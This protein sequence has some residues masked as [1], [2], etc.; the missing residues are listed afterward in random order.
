MS[1]DGARFSEL[2]MDCATLCVAPVWAS[3]G[4]SAL[5]ASVDHNGTATFIDTGKRRILVTAYHVLAKVRE[6]QA[7]NPG[8]G[9][10][11]NLASGVTPFYPQFDVVAEDPAADIAVLSFPF[12]QDWRGHAKRYFPIRQWPIP[13]PSKGEAVTIVGFP[14][15]M[16]RTFGSYGSFSPY[17][18]GMVVSND[19]G[20]HVVLANES[21]LT[22]VEN[23]VSRPG[24]IEPGGMSGAAGFILRG[25]CVHLA[26]FVY[27]GNADMLF[28]TPGSRL[29]IDGILH[30]RLPTSV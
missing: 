19:P 6:V 4:E 14:G 18:I 20:R 10:A 17:G 8:A 1:P 29:H 9:L 27:E 12:L 11:V 7:Q 21:R 24:G 30:P 2:I 3:L 16:R 22:T 26:G 13:I 15:V 28:L 5:A 25:D 23:G